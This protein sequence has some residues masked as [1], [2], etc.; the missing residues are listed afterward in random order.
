[1]NPRFADLLATVRDVMPD[2]P[3]QWH[4]NGTMLTHKRVREILAVDWPHKI[5]VSIDGGN[6][7]SHDL[8]RGK[9]TFRKTMRGLETLLEHGKGRA[10]LT[11]GVYQI[12]L[13]ES[14]E[15]YDDE[16]RRLVAMVDDHVKVKALV[17]GGAEHNITS[18][19]TLE[20]DETLDRMV[21]E[22]VAAFMPVP[23]GPCF[24][25]GHVLCVAPDGQVWICVISHGKLGVVGN[26]VTESAEV[27]V[28]RA[29]AF[30]AEL[31]AKGRQNMQHCRTCRKPE[32]RI[33]AKNLAPDAEAA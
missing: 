7:R 4:T 31:A 20:S 27:V 33:F 26:L 25:A 13:G 17:P 29:L 8:N 10:G 15:N 18:A 11:I 12:D 5:F 21:A 9:G 30:R 3:L 1:M 2:I 32:G 28:G 24:W 19:D 16:F 14:E 22:E 6:E 23:Q